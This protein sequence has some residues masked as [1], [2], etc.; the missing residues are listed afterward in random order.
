MAS[1]G[2]LTLYAGATKVL[3]VQKCVAN[4]DLLRYKPWEVRDSEI[5]ALKVS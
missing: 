3:R 2:R 5:A 1:G 4:D